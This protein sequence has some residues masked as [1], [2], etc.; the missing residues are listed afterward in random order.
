MLVGCAGLSLDTV[1]GVVR[2]Y[3]PRLECGEVIG[4]YDVDL[5]SVSLVVQSDD[6]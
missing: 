3:L 2:A 1:I 6:L 5:D 4:S